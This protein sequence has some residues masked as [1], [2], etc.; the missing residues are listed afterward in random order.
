MDPARLRQLSS[1]QYA[2]LPEIASRRNDIT[3]PWVA[4]LD[5]P[6]D[7]TLQ[8]A[9][10]DWSIYEALL[11]DDQ[12]FSTFQQRRLAV[13]SR[14][15][16]VVPG[17]SRRIDKA[18]AD[19]ISE[20]IAEPSLTSPPPEQINGQSLVGFDALTDKMLFGRF[21][22]YA[23]A[24]LIYAQDGRF[25][26]PQQI[27]VRK[28]RRFRFDADGHLRMLT[29]RDASGEKIQE[30]YPHKFWVF[31]CGGETDD[32]PYRGNG[33]APIVYWPVWFKRNGL[34]FWSTYLE[35]NSR[36][37][38][39]G[40]H[41]AAASEA[42]IA[43]LLAAVEAVQEGAA[44]TIPEGM[45]L[46][47]LEATNRAD[48]YEQFAAY[49][50]RAIA[51]TVLGQVMTSE[52][53]GGQY[54]AEIQFDVRAELIRSDSD[55]VNGSANLTWVRWLTQWNFP[56]AAAPRIWRRLTDEPDLKPQAERDNIIVG[57]GFSPTEEY[58]QGTYGEGFALP[59]AQAAAAPTDAPTDAPITPDSPEVD[60]QA[61]ALNGAQIKSLVEVVQ[62]V[63]GGLLPLESAVLLVQIS[64]PRVSAEQA[65]ALLQPA[66][67]AMP[68]P[69]PQAELSDPLPTPSPPPAPAADSDPEE[70]FAAAENAALP[71]TEYARRSVARVATTLGP[72]VDGW[73]DQVQALMESAGSLEE[74]GE[75]L[76]GL[77]PELDKTQ[78]AEQFRY[79]LLAVQAAGMAEVAAEGGDID[80]DS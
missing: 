33:L 34:K 45:I 55:L 12:V 40:K 16:E 10:W 20:V 66:Q 76:A 42:D 2:G 3:R 53:V 61:T 1:R 7:L 27:K 47:L 17:G 62:A 52:A 69:A 58:V 44:V 26:Y 36:P 73:V 39:A 30:L 14:E 13:V 78:F 71:P 75:A 50:D 19:F 57:W 59:A 56:G 4:E 64:F 41:G 31:Q 38:M 49:W 15:Y 11:R 46:E 68:A 25:T 67:G 65:R 37:R 22:G 60:V 43:N 32:D 48:S 5:L 9:S 70:Q 8:D 28:Q 23:V 74:F 6:D 51:K 21:W 18:A 35:T 29:W 80:A 24:E 72:V 79:G 77:Y 54:K 63:A